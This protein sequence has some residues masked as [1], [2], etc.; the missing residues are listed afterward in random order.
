MSVNTH[1]RYRIKT[2]ADITETVARRGEGIGYQQRQNFM[3][4]LQTIGIRANPSDVTC[5]VEE[6]TLLGLGFGKKYRGTQAVWTLDFTIEYGETSIEF[7]QTDFD[8][9]PVTVGLTET[10]KI[11]KGIF[12]TKDLNLTNIIFETID[13]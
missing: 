12:F 6:D 4:V 3:S 9:V 2:L 1:M 5:T 10:A 7:L 8:L 11:Q 13:K